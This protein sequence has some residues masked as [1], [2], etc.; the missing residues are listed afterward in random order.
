MKIPA[1]LITQYANIDENVSIRRW[2]EK[3]PV[4]L[5]HDEADAYTI[6]DSIEKCVSEL[7]GDLPESRIPYR[8]LLCITNIENQSGEKVVDVIIPGWNPRQA[9]RFPASLIPKELQDKL[10]PETWFLAWVN[11]GAEKDEDLYF[12]DFELAPEPDEDDGLA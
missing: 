5:R 9:V 10:V 8:E 12:R 1:V 4:V 3:I 11:I 2:R 6:R 7:Q